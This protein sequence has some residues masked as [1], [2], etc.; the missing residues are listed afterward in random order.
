MEYKSALPYPEI[1]V[2]GKNIEYAKM[3][4]T[5]YAGNVSEDTAIHLYMYQSVVLNNKYSNIFENIAKVE[6]YHLKLLA[7]TIE[8][9]GLE[10]KYQIYCDNIIDFNSSYVNYDTNINNILQID[11]LSES[12]AIENYKKLI[13]LID[14]KYIKNLLN[15]IILDEQ[16]HL[17]IFNEL[18]RQI[19]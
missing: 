14:D 9:L 7:K 6:M 13:D 8:L 11:I 15:R 19:I 3:L 12:L 18:K 5:S 16:I 4:A 1:K 17:N 10:P 2:E